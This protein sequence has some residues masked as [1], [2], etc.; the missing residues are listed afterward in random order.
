MKKLIL[1]SFLFL[2]GC[3]SNNFP[4]CEK[5]TYLNKNNDVKTTLYIQKNGQM[6]KEVQTPRKTFSEKGLYTVQ[7]DSLTVYIKNKK[8]TYLIQD[9]VDVLLDLS[10]NRKLHCN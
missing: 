6:E 10:T 8:E 4:F 3:T 2:F 1:F 9:D 5:Y 7:S